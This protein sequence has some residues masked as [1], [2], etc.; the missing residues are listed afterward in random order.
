MPSYAQEVK[1]ELSR[2]LDDDRSCQL[3]E[4]V[5]LMRVGANATRAIVSENVTKAMPNKAAP[6]NK[7]L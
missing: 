4:F 3:A 7:N 5:A 6:G 1:N 2:K